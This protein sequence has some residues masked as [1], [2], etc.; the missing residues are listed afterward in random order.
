VLKLQRVMKLPE[1]ITLYRGLGKAKLPDEFFRLDEYGTK[2]LTEF[3]FMST[4]PNKSVALSYSRVKDGNPIATVLALQCGSVDRAACIKDFSQYPG[5]EEYLWVPMTFLEPFGQQ[6]MEVTPDG[7]VT[8]IPVRA[9]AN[10]KSQ[11]VEELQARKKT[12][13]VTTFENLMYDIERD[14]NFHI[15]SMEAQNHPSLHH[16]HR[17]KQIAVDEC[18][19]VLDK[20]RSHPVE[21][22]LD[23][24]QYKGAVI[25]MLDFR[26]MAMGMFE[27]AEEFNAEAGAQFRLREIYRL[28]LGNMTQIVRNSADYDESRVKDVAFKLCK[29]QGLVHKDL[30]ET[31]EL[32]ETPLVRASAEG[33]HL[34]AQVLLA[35]GADPNSVQYSDW[36]GW[37]Y[38]AYQGHDEVIKV[39]REAEA[40]VDVEKSLEGDYTAL[41]Y[42]C[43]NDSIRSMEELLWM[44]A[45]PDT[46]SSSWGFTA[47]M[48]AADNG[49][50]KCAQKLVDSGAGVNFRDA[51]GISTLGHARQSSYFS[52]E[53][54]DLL[55]SKGAEE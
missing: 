5:E 19:V 18:Q 49:A 30:E 8:V 50:L 13:H 10:L 40:E 32:Q 2:G 53:I 33:D 4:T 31:N 15:E 1:G 36:P 22:Y 37:G 44:G 24:Y 45:S 42:A 11:T 28:Y 34:S 25:E 35:A 21:F 16:F 6:S 26:E 23:D 54:V 48:I 29:V 41:M 52:Q 43:L 51:D 20:H 17:M 9:N 12:I 39:F 55:V 3:G 46:Q 27:Y 38:A 47:L 7:P 14:L